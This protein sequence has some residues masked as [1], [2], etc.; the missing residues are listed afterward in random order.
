VKA[1]EVMTMYRSFLIT[2]FIDLFT[3]GLIPTDLK[4][5]TRADKLINVKTQNSSEIFVP[6]YISDPPLRH[7]SYMHSHIGL[8]LDGLLIVQ[9]RFLSELFILDS[10]VFGESVCLHSLLKHF[11]KLL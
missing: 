7:Y 8:D 4:T 6:L 10:L 3:L 1:D 11:I 5:W 9:S 2:I